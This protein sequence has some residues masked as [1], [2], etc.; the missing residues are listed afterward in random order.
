MAGQSKE[1]AANQRHTIAVLLTQN[2][3]IREIAKAVGCSPATVQS[4][5][6]KMKDPD[7]NLAHDG[8]ELNK[9]EAIIPQKVWNII[10]EMRIETQYG[11]R[12]I[13]A[14]L[15]RN[16]EKFGIE[17]EEIPGESTI[18]NYLRFKKLT[19]KLT[20]KADNRSWPI[21]FDEDLG[22]IAID[23]HGPMR[24]GNDEIYAVTVQDRHS[25]LS[26]AFPSL[27]K[28]RGMTNDQWIH[29][30]IRA[31]EHIMQCNYDEHGQPR[32][33]N[34][35]FA[36]NGEMGMAN[37]HSKQPVRYAMKL[38]AR[39]VL[40]A[41]G[42][43][44]KNGRLENWHHRLDVEFMEKMERQHHEQVRQGERSRRADT[45]RIMNG[46][47]THCNDYNIH[48]PHSALP[49]MAA[50]ADL[51]SFV[52]YTPEDAQIQEYPELGPQ[53]GII[54]VIRLVWNNGKIDLWG[55]D[56][57]HIQPLLGGQYVRIRFYCDPNSEEQ[58][59]KV[60]WQK[61]QH[62]MPVVVAMFSHTLDRHRTRNQPFI[63][64]MTF[65]DIDVSSPE[66]VLSPAALAVIERQKLNEPAVRKQYG[67][68]TKKKRRY[69]EEQEPTTDIH[70]EVMQPTPAATRR[71]RKK[72]TN[73]G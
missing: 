50:P 15:Q 18:L 71:S 40:N 33:I 43:P 66:S 69:Q 47:I 13:W 73:G 28:V 70:G 9:R 12:L 7:A 14:M 46:M 61:S 52:P 42:R 34:T 64:S 48:R 58:L 23:G 41:P 68:I 2:Q 22:V 65:Q 1:K 59:G 6:N 21:D 38:G 3:S 17:L 24:W 39:V 11:P 25:R 37:G 35:L 72:A 19:Q 8:R 49:K 62:S 20:G 45:R 51:Y 4:V 16:H 32:H 57:M 36:D 27:G 29:A 67:K 30:I 56:E 55:E 63:T 60:I 10:T 5:K 53:E 31:D 44:Q 54:D 26:M